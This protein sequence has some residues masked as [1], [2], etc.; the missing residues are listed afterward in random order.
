MSEHDEDVSTNGSPAMSR[1]SFVTKVAATAA[2]FAI[3]PRP[4]L[5]K[6][7]TPPSDI[8]NV[9]CV[10]VGGQGR[11]NLINLASQNVVALCDVDWDYAGK[12]LER[13][14]AHIESA[15]KQLAATPANP[16][17]GRH[18]QPVPP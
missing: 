9:A 18:A 13:L 8:L 10:G 6:G 16:P 2:G 3:V 7:L 17:P 11:S 4:R 5:G 12:A 14:D 15:Q 1:R